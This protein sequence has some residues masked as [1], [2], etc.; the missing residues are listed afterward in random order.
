MYRT[1]FRQID[2]RVRNFGEHLNR[3]GLHLSESDREGIRA[4]L[5]G[6]GQGSFFP[7]IEA[8]RSYWNVRL[9]P[10]VPTAERICV[11][12]Q[13]LRDQRRAPASYGV[14]YPWLKHHLDRV[15]HAGADEGLLSDG[16]GRVLQGIFS[17]IIVITGATAHISTHP[18]SHASVL[19]EPVLDYLVSLGVDVHPHDKGLPP[20]LLG[21]GEVWYVDSLAG[22][23]QV[24]RW[25]EY[26]T[27]RPARTHS[28][29]HIDVTAANAWLW[30]H[31]D[32]V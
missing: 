14:D 29:P 32:T 24:E 28:S 18:S 7:I 20:Y 10:D 26:G 5:R 11:A 16:H 12:A 9:R 3:L 30:D 25:M 2:G 19:R 1:S 21:R 17:T 8:E 13:L 6:A 22:V 23:R 4:Q 15:I 31:A 27:T